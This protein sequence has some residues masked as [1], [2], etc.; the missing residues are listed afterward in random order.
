[1]NLDQFDIRQFDLDR[2]TT[3]YLKEYHQVGTYDTFY[4]V[5]PKRRINEGIIS[6]QLH[7]AKEMFY[8]K[9]ATLLPP[10][11]KKLDIYPDIPQDYE[12][13]PSVCTLVR[14][15]C[16]HPIKKKDY[17]YSEAVLVWFQDDF[18][19]DIGE[20]N[21]ANLKQIEWKKIAEDKE[22]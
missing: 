20:Q 12:I 10:E 15:R 6:R 22:N 18:G 11:I 9:Q 21:V 17:D 13:L 4:E 16:L 14:Y 8:S 3:L 2:K 19:L 1:M 7:D 5:T